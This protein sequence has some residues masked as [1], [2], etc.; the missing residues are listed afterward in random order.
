MKD[1]AKLKYKQKLE[2]VIVKIKRLNEEY[3]KELIEID[4]KYRE[5]SE[6]ISNE[7]EYRKKENN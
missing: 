4:D 3:Q 1:K 6:E 5:N 2:L 7:L